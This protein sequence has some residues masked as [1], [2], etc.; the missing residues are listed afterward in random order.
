[1]T[2]IEKTY[3]YCH[4]CSTPF[5]VLDLVSLHIEGGQRVYSDGSA[6]FWHDSTE[7]FVRCGFCE[8]ILDVNKLKTTKDNPPEIVNGA[9]VF[10]IEERQCIPSKSLSCFKLAQEVSALPFEEAYGILI[11]RWRR[12]NKS[13][14]KSRQFFDN[15]QLFLVNYLADNAPIK[16]I[17]QHITR[18]ELHRELKRFDDCLSV[19]KD[20]NSI[21]TVKQCDQYYDVLHVMEWAARNKVY[22][23]LAITQ[24][25][26]YPSPLIH[27]PTPPHIDGWMNV[28]EVIKARAV[29]HA[30][31]MEHVLSLNDFTFEEVDQGYNGADIDL[32]GNVISCVS[33]YD[34]HSASTNLVIRINIGTQF[35]F[36]EEG[37]LLQVQVGCNNQSEDYDTF[38]Y[39]S[40]RRGAIFIGE[41]LWQAEVIFDINARHN[42]YSQEK[43]APLITKLN[44]LIKA[45]L[46]KDRDELSDDV[47]LQ[48]EASYNV[49]TH[50]EYII[51]HSSIEFTNDLLAAFINSQYV[52]NHTPLPPLII[53][54]KNTEIDALLSRHG[55]QCGVFITAWNP[56]S[57]QFT[58]QENNLK[59]SALM[60]SIDTQRHHVYEA[61]GQS[62]DK[63]WQESSLFIIN[64]TQ[65]EG[66]SLAQQYGQL[67]FVYHEYGSAT[68]LVL[69][70]LPSE[71][72]YFGEE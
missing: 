6:G 33:E 21:Y 9:L 10:D 31:S 58:Q 61:V 32:Q 56:Y 50:S 68:Q 34:F 5:E 57:R 41:N 27:D 14:S 22:D 63:Q 62:S 67:G 38:E 49:I 43:S 25:D 54:H 26:S 64:M 66:H 30:Y 24:I 69:S 72:I 65:E 44:E 3:K 2:I 46:Q 60:S 40:V 4:E 35:I 37:Q 45:N 7:R 13:R 53:G 16:T 19:I 36:D 17:E 28:N 15:D 71:T 29:K 42:A 70:D 8:V 11:H 39:I 12:I 18:A 20:I 52:V 55:S 48:W 47:I 23:V 1:M 59:Q 51:D